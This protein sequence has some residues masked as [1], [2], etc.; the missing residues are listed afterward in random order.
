MVRGPSRAVTRSE[1]FEEIEPGTPETASTLAEN[2]DVHQD[3]VYSRLTELHELDKV[4][5][6]QPGARARV[7]WIPSPDTTVDA[8]VVRDSMFQSSKDPDIIRE[9]AKAMNRGEPITSGE[10]VDETGETQDITYNR[11]R[12]LDN[13]GWVESLKAGST[14]KVWWLNTERFKNEIAAEADA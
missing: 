12:K 5:T 11:L 8:G 9:L 13:R 1:V 6:K 3:T 2:F 10:I 14:S 7:W 4:K